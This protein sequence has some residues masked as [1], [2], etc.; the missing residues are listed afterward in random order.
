M[1][2]ENTT[3]RGS[4]LRGILLWI[5]VGSGLL[6]GVVNTVNKVVNLFGG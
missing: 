4:E 2:T 5:L 1:S 3:A 6:Y